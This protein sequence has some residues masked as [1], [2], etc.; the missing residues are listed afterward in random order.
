MGSPT[1]NQR[2]DLLASLA[3]L[4]CVVLIALAGLALDGNWPKVARVSAAA[5]TYVVVLL[6][7]AGRR[8]Q[9]G[10]MHRLPYYPFAL[11]GALAGIVSGLM[12]RVPSTRLVLGVALAA[13]LLLGGLH[14][15]A[16]RSWRGV[17]A[18][19]TGAAE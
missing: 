11:A 18:R 5:A 2:S 1:P 6:V 17:R 15:M 14:W 12:Q 8:A 4:A 19:V 10:G 16:L 3:L 7:L 13:A 9:A